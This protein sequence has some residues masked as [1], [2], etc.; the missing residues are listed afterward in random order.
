MLGDEPVRQPGGG[1]PQH[2]VADPELQPTRRRYLGHH[3][4]F[5]LDA[6]GE[7]GHVEVAVAALDIDQQVQV[8]VGGRLAAR[9]RSEDPDVAH[10]EA[11]AE[12]FDRI[13]VRAYLVHR[14]GTTRSRNLHLAPP[15][16]SHRLEAK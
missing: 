9:H 11:L 7:P 12:P 6:E 14:D 10:A 5:V 15:L 16:S 3:A 13:P 2:A 1:L 4:E 8:A